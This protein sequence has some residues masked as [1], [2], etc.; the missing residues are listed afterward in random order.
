[1]NELTRDLLILAALLAPI[2]A[3]AIGRVV[4]HRQ[5]RG[6]RATLFTTLAN[7]TR[8]LAEIHIAEAQALDVV[9]A[10]RQLLETMSSAAEQLG[11]QPGPIS[12]AQHRL[13]WAARKA[14]TELL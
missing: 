12:E 1:M 8:K 14:R 4:E 13:A 9:R 10:Q 6:Q 3:Y 2:G 7:T 11:R 5:W